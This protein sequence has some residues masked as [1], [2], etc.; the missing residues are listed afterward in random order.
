MMVNFVS[1]SGVSNKEQLKNIKEITLEERIDFP[2]AIGFQLSNR[3][4]NEGTQN[5]RQP[6]FSELAELD[7]L[8][9]KYNFLTALHYYTKDNNTIVSDIKRIFHSKIRDKVLIQFNTLPPSLEILEKTKELGFKVIFKVAVA[10]KSSGEGYKIWKGNSA[11]DSINGS[12]DVLFQQAYER[13]KFIDYILFDP[14]HG[15]NQAIDLS[16][17]SLAIRFGKKIISE[18]CFDGV[19]LIYAGGI[20]PEN[21]MNVSKILEENFPNRVSIDAEGGLRKE[22]ILDMNLIR[23]YLIGYKAV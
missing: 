7:I 23:E 12:E 22:N 16:E 10:D 8:S 13:R 15:R 19:G 1:I 17:K 4:I 6:L 20:K 21:V 5:P 18:K 11:E 3:S 9:R 2:V 14:S